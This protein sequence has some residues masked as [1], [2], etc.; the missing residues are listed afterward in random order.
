MIQK[1]KIDKQHILFLK[2][3]SHPIV[4]KLNK[5]QFVTS[6]GLIYD[7]TQT[8]EYRRNKILTTLETV[9]KKSNPIKKCNRNEILRAH[10]LVQKI[11]KKSYFYGWDRW[12]F[13]CGLKSLLAICDGHIIPLTFEGR[14]AGIIKCNE[15]YEILKIM[16]NNFYHSTILKNLNLDEVNYRYYAKFHAAEY[17]FYH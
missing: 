2:E 9:L 7:F 12:A 15:I 5:R 10:D 8:H 6:E 17:P 14:N 3:I 13:D 16:E 4:A 1:S 11:Y